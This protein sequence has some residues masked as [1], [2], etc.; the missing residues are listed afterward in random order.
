MKINILCSVIAACISMTAVSMFNADPN[1]A[2]CQRWAEQERNQ[3][4]MRQREQQRIQDQ[5]RGNAAL[6]GV[7]QSKGLPVPSQIMVQLDPVA[8]AVACQHNQNVLQRQKK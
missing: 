3:Q 5:M 7:Y 4:M 6:A 2:M 1:A 8:H